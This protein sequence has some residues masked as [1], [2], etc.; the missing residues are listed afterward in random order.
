MHYCKLNLLEWLYF[1]SLEMKTV[2]SFFFLLVFNIS[3]VDFPAKQGHIVVPQWRRNGE[4]SR[5]PAGPSERA[6]TSSIY[7]MPYEM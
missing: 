5:S 1:S 7:E 2:P 4:L 3:I 6:L